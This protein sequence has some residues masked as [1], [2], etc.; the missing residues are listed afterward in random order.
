MAGKFQASTASYSWDVTEALDGLYRVVYI[1]HIY[2]VADVSR[3]Y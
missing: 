2:R 1:A 3:E